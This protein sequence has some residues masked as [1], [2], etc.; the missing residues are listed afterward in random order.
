MLRAIRFVDL[1]KSAAKLRSE[2]Q[3]LVTTDVGVAMRFATLPAQRSH[4]GDGSSNSGHRLLPQLSKRAS[5]VMRP[6]CSAAWH[7]CAASIISVRDIRGLLL[8]QPNG[9]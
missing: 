3:N 4:L 1:G 6:R 8:T 7:S 2:P 9:G 5:G